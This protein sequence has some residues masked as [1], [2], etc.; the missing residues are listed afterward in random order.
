MVV[1]VSSGLWP[2][3]L[4]AAFHA[5]GDGH[6]ALGDSGY[7]LLLALEKTESK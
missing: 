2:V 3:H 7:I 1:V 4:A 6:R 5:W